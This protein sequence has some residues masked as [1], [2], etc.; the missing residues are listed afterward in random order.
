[1]KKLNVLITH[2]SYQAAAGSFIKMLRASKL[3]DFYIVGTDEIPK[4]YSSGSMLVDKFYHIPLN[5]AIDRYVEIVTNICNEEQ[6]DIIISA[7]ENDLIV[8]K[9]KQIKQ[10]YPE[11]IADKKIFKL[12]EDKY[13][14]NIEISKLGI[15][16]PTT[17]FNMGDLNK[18]NSIKCIYRKRIS[19][20]SRG[21]KIFNRG[22][23]ESDY[24]FYSNNHISQEYIEGRM[25]TIDVLCDKSG[26]I[27]MIVPRETLSLKDGT[28]FKCIIEKNDLLIDVCK[29]VYNKFSIP[30]FSNIQFIV[31]KDKP[32]FIELNPRCAA[33]L[34]ASSLVSI[35]FLDFV[36]GERIDN[37][38]IP[39]YEELMKTVKWGSVISRYYEE[40][41]FEGN[42]I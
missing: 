41:V 26:N 38:E 5:C 19:C 8:Y 20:C 31:D 14:A 15:P 28:T 30:G 23:I 42:Q 7:E 22:E 17:Y 1:M 12:F 10:A 29:T 11:Y 16:I 40:T 9:D 3:Y 32:Y 13:Y 34:I 33:T 37:L 2:V 39:P 24:V 21:I 4:G 36:I 6:I 25:F 35:N 18:S 27:H